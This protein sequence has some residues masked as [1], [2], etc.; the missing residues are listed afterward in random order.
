VCSVRASK[1]VQ[2]KDSEHDARDEPHASLFMTE[3]AP[4]ALQS[5]KWAQKRAVFTTTVAVVCVCVCVCVL[6]VCVCHKWWWGYV[7][8]LIRRRELIP[9]KPC[10]AKQA[11]EVV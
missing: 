3:G 8:S 6:C 10:N 2:S 9:A 1:K 7:L 5:N 11:A 4:F